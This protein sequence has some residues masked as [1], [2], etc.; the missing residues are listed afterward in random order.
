VT[1]DGLAKTFLEL[2]C[3]GEPL[4]QPNAWDAG[5]ARM[6]AALGYR[7]IATT[8]SGFAATLGRLDG[9][10]TRDE[11]L[12][13]C[14]Q[15]AAVVD[16]P[17]AA[18][19]ENGYADDPAQVAETVRLAAQTGLA[20][21]SVE[22]YARDSDRIYDKALA[23]ERVAAAA[24]AAHAGPQQLVLTARAENHIH[25]HDD[26]A[27]TIERLHAYQQAGADVLFAPG[28]VRAEDLRT[29]LAEVDRPVNVLAMPGCP[30]V[31]ELA[32]LGVARISVG[33]AFAFTAYAALI[34]A[35]RELQD[36]GTYDYLQRVGPARSAIRA[37]LTD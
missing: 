29:L 13:H 2:H 25:G 6:L 17:L 11:V 32:D 14:A 37:A 15:L 35:A 36:S 9:R 24:E 30:T 19:L 34:E 23:T 7:A 27:D 26:L 28:V 12:A 1:L 16:V 8:S 33:G 5:S 31:S 18:D 20:G 3:P 4:L 10:V 21:C 22:D